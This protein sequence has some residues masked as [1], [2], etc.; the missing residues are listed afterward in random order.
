MKNIT[1]LY[2]KV[3]ISIHDFLN[4]DKFNNIVLLS[5]GTILLYHNTKE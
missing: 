5:R 4:Y 3:L 1:R 2:E